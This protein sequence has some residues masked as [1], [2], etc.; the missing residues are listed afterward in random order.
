MRLL[1]A[2]IVALLSGCALSGPV[3]A[4]IVHG[5]ATIRSSELISADTGY[6][7]DRSSWSSDPPT[8][9]VF[10]YD[11]PRP[12]FLFVRNVTGSVVGVGQG[13]VPEIGVGAEGEMSIHSLLRG[14][15][16][17]GRLSWSAAGVRLDG[18]PLEIG[19]TRTV[20]VVQTLRDGGTANETLALT[21]WGIGTVTTERPPWNFGCD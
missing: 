17:L 14:G 2:L 19:K 11:G 10:P 20:S 3:E 1:L 18:E 5:L 8:A 6:H 9:H 4:H 15:A 7:C 16:T 13:R 12:G 21:A